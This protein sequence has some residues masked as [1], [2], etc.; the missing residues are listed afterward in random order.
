MKEQNIQRN[1][2]VRA[3]F[4]ARGTSFHA[5]CTQNGID[6]HNARKAVLGIWSGPK[7]QAII[8][9]IKLELGEVF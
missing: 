8:E 3:A 5:W 1:N 4:V 2:R 9:K 6:S 7:A